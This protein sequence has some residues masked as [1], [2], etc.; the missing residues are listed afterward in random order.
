MEL[1]ASKIKIDGE[2]VRATGSL[3][4]KLVV[5]FFKLLFLLF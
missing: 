4:E 3:F 1:C 2:A 5:V